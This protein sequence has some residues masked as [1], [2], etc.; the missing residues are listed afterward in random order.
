MRLMCFY[1]RMCRTNRTCAEPCWHSTSDVVVV[2]ASVRRCD[3]AR[4]DSM[5]MSMGVE[6]KGRMCRRDDVCFIS[7]HFGKLER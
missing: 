4:L 5:G 3:D 7:V 2:N 6:G 1:I